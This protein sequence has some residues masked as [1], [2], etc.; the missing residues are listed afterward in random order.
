MAS[1][2]ST[3]DAWWQDPRAHLGVRLIPFIYAVAFASTAIF[4]LVLPDD[5][6]W[7]RVIVG[8]LVAATIASWWLS[9]RLAPQTNHLVNY[10]GM[11]FGAVLTSIHSPLRWMIA[12]AVA[13]GFISGL[14]RRHSRVEALIAGALTPIVLTFT[15]RLH[16][17][18][19]AWAITSAIFGAMLILRAD[20]DWTRVN[21]RRE[22]DTLSDMS[23]VSGSFVWEGDF[24]SGRLVGATGDVAGV[25]GYSAKEFVASGIYSNMHP[26]DAY[27]WIDPSRG[28]LDGRVIKRNVRLRHR[29]GHWVTLAE[30]LKV[31]VGPNG[32]TFLRG[33]SSDISRARDAEQS[34]ERYRG[35][36]SRIRASVVICH[37]DAR[38]TVIVDEIN[39]TAAQRFNIDMVDSVGQPLVE[40][41]QWCGE[42]VIQ[43][44]LSRMVGPEPDKV[45]LTRFSPTSVDVAP[46]APPVVLDIEVVPLNEGLF[47]V[48]MHDISDVVAGEQTIRHQANH[49]GLT[50][51][52]N[53][54]MFMAAAVEAL[55]ARS[56]DECVGLLM[57]DFDRFKEINDTLGHTVGDD[58][59]RI[60]S[61]RL[62]T[63]FARDDVIVARIGGDEFALLITGNPSIA[64]L[65]AIADET[66]D[67]VSQPSTVAGMGLRISA[68]VGIACAP[69]HGTDV[70]TLFRYA[71]IAMYKAK[72][73][74]SRW[75]VYDGEDSEHAVQR[76][77]LASELHQALQSDQF[78]LWFQPQCDLRD[79]RLV[80]FEGLARWRHP[81]LGVLSPDQFLDVVEVSDQR[82][83]F[84]RRVISLGA[85]FA[86]QCRSAGLALR[87]GV[88][89]GA[90][91]LIGAHAADQ[92]A[93]ELAATDIEP[94]DL[95]IEVTEDALTG[96]TSMVADQVREL[97]SLGVGMSIDDFGT[98][99]SSLGRLRS[100]AMS[101][102]KIDRTFVEQLRSDDVFIV[103]T[104]VHLAIDLGLRCIAEGIDDAAT[105][106]RLLSF[107]CSLGQGYG[108]A[109]PMPQPDA[110]ELVRSLAGYDE[111]VLQLPL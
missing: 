61:Q 15:A 105:V 109:R 68:S 58:L 45:L 99:H 85:A 17:I 9:S 66:C 2:N 46:A 10:L 101:E 48:V 103:R 111:P 39:A 87:V 108:I 1:D 53:R 8:Y 4:N 89:I 33:V 63:T 13:L 24:E 97:A 18:E 78:E 32:A 65:R 34:R 23:T 95:V 27:Q 71:D 50:G 100:L 77:M 79:G 82:E 84:D 75:M 107:G 106:D 16:D 98:G 11:L 74:G 72:S 5:G 76:L 35:V 49:D 59:L 26:D 54:F 22:R 104:I 42:P 44:A 88:N 37:H 91:S 41:V 70:T 28:D 29:D 55:E 86:Q 81:T 80:G 7:Q 60:I 38:G 90:S 94:S 102:L 51:L 47:A 31:R 40:T 6:D 96:D 21:R 57:V 67:A 36:V 62:A 83:T 20:V 93:I 25:T 43:T 56:G 110:L 12:A 14:N 64:Q 52:P 19:H 30:E 3:S 73:I 92:V 69:D